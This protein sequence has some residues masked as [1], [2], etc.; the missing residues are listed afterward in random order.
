VLDTLFEAGFNQEDFLMADIRSMT[1]M[2]ETNLNKGKGTV[3]WGRLATSQV[4]I[5]DV[6]PPS[7]L[8]SRGCGR[9]SKDHI[10]AKI[11]GLGERIGANAQS[12]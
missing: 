7:A 1:T 12:V 8:V 3:G 11:A 4:K 10:G 2:L 5:R 9:Y 6:D